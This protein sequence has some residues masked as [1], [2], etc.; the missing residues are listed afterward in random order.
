M[1][2]TKHDPSRYTELRNPKALRDFFV[3]DKF[4][5]GIKLAGT[6]VKSIRAGKAQITDAFA[7]LEKGGVWLYGAYVEEYS[8]GGLSQH[9]PR[10]VR[11]LL[12]NANEIRK[13]QQQVE[14]GGRSIVALRMYFKQALVKVEI[15]TATGK[16]QFDK[17]ADIKKRELNLE[18]R[19][20]LK[21]RK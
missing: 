14:T 12:L 15:A 2:A 16:K 20:A 19:K 10:R 1:A 21:F 4:E 3:H 6:E 8:H 5:A 11:Q 18:A 7:R 9:A 13:L 17:R